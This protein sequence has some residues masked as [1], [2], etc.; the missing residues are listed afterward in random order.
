MLTEDVVA[1]LDE[2]LTI[3]GVPN[4]VDGEQQGWLDITSLDFRPRSESE[5]HL[6]LRFMVCDGYVREIRTGLADYLWD[7]YPGEFSC[8]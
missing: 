8:S 4:M 3:D 5:Q 2:R 7:D 6:A 1:A